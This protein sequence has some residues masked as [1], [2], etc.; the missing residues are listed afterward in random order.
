MLDI[1]DL[2]KRGSAKIPMQIVTMIRVANLVERPDSSAVPG[3]S[4]GPSSSTA[5]GGQ[6]EG[7]LEA[8]ENS[9]VR[10]LPSMV[11]F[12]VTTAPFSSLRP[13]QRVCMMSSSIQR[14]RQCLN[15]SEW[16][17][18]DDWRRSVYRLS[19][20]VVASGAFNSRFQSLV[21]H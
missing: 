18:T 3:P 20:G 19:R 8:S 9:A 14:A 12:L 5:M 17:S 11:V 13:L 16:P 21:R 10:H 7:P 2:E 6:R 1:A 4:P 15:G